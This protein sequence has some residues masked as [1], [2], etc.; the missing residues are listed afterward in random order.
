MTRTFIIKP[1][2]GAKVPDPLT[3]EPLKAEGEEKPKSEYW[4]R[5]ILD[6]SV[7]EVKPTT[8]KT[9]TK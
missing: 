5:R 6:K 1:V 9:E 3:R 2:D 8:K 7:V 4:K